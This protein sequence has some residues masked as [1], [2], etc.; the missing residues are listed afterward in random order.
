[1][2]RPGMPMRPPIE[3]LFTIAPLS[4]LRI[5]SNSYFI[6]SHTL[7]RLIAFTRSNSSLVVSAVSTARL[8]NAGIIERGIQAPECR[9]GF[10]DHPLYL[11]FISD[12]AGD[13]DRLMACSNELLRDPAHRRL[14][15]IDQRNRSTRRSKCLRRSEAHAR[16]SAGDECDF[17]FK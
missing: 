16:A 5:W 8:C 17:V 11:G 10:F 1:M 6:H 2:A 12:I 15:D 14:I 7:R 4:C 13:G 3:E 9:D